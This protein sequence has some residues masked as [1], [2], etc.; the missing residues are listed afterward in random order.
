MGI[1]FSFLISFFSEGDEIKLILLFLRRKSFF[2]LK[3]FP[4]LKLFLL[5]LFEKIL[6]ISSFYRL[7][8]RPGMLSGRDYWVN[9]VIVIN[10]VV[11]FH[12]IFFLLFDFHLFQVLLFKLIL[13]LSVISHSIL[14]F[15]LVFHL[16]EHNL[17][18]FLFF[19]FKFLE[20]LFLMTLN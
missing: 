20:S 7:N 8:G 6:F 10:L 1:F 5:N 3:L 17:L 15:S 16:I 11:L 12:L 19:S 18:I 14:F 13:L 4:F 9:N 2:I